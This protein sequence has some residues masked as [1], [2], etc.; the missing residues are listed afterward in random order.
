[1]PNLLIPRSLVENQ[2]HL[3]IEFVLPF[4]AADQLPLAQDVSLHRRQ[5]LLF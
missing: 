2:L 3:E 5:Q 1:M 4:V